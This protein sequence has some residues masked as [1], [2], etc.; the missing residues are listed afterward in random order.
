MT[1]AQTSS[2]VWLNGGITASAEARIS[3]FD[4]GFLFGDGAF[5]TLRAYCG[6]PFAVTRHWER[7]RASC[8]ILG[9]KPPSAAEFSKALAEV[10]ASNN[11]TQARLRFTVSR[12]EDS[13]T[14][15]TLLA[16]ASALPVW[17]SAASVC[18]VPWA[19]NERSPLAGAKSISYSENSLALAWAKQRGADE[20]IF[21]NTRGLLCEGTGS[22]VFLVHDGVL[23]TPPLSSGCLAGVTRALVLELARN[24]GIAVEETPLSVSA[25]AESDEA[26]LTSTT[27][28]VQPIAQVDGGDLSQSPGLICRRLVELFHRLTLHDDNP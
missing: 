8:E 6:T 1:S 4:R 27:R 22:N 17:P 16:S 7:L 28:E 24:D 10:L 11:L 19:R 3:P 13:N 14:G 2:K 25:L 21:A 23:M 20:G 9:L 26:F 5:E 18:T 12:G 15:A